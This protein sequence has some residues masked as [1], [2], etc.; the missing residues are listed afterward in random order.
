MPDMLYLDLAKALLFNLTVMF[1]TAHLIISLRVSPLRLGRAPDRLGA[2]VL[3]SGLTLLGML[4]AYTDVGHIRLDMR[5][6]ILGF[7]AWIGGPSVG[8]ATMAVATVARFALGGPGTSGGI[9]TI[10]ASALVGLLLYGRRRTPLTVTLFACG[11]WVASW[12]GLEVLHRPV[13]MGFVV[14]VMLLYTLSAAWAFHFLAREMESKVGLK[15]QLYE[16][17]RL[18]ETVLEMVD[19]GIVCIT[20]DGTVGVANGAARRVLGLTSDPVGARA[21]SLF[22]D[23]PG[24]VERIATRERFVHELHTVTVPRP[25][26]AEPGADGAER[27]EVILAVTGVPLDSGMVLAFSDVTQVIVTERNAARQRRLQML[28]ELAAMA[29]HEIKNPLTAIKG[30]LQLLAAAPRPEQARQYVGI[31]QGEAELINRVVTDFLVLGKTQ[32]DDVTTFEIAPLLFEVEQE[33]GLRFPGQGV[34]VSTELGVS[35]LT[36]DRQALKQILINLLSN[37]Y[38]AMAANGA[39][40]VAIGSEGDDGLIAVTDSGPGIAPEVLPE[41]FRPFKTTKASGVGLGL[42][43]CER[44]VS[45][46]RGRISAESPPGGGATFRVVLPGAAGAAA[47]QRSA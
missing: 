37:A 32:A 43:I 17:L 14:P 33:I 2:T 40:W 24:L 28:G 3:F 25:A 4:L 19:C 44:L 23:T 5:A 22:A 26:A 42:A 47:N 29:A 20:C 34:V 31:M 7:A 30:F 11:A 27:L 36:S 38:E 35:V 41:L 6:P 12:I 45:N 15:E 1:T 18:K 39:L 9:V 13:P 46:L 10:V 8:L 16:E 21:Q